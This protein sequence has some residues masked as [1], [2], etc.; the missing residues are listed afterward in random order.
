MDKETILL[1]LEWY[2]AY[3][4][5]AYTSNNKIFIVLDNEDE[6]HVEVSKDEIEYRS[7]LEIYKN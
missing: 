3:G 1:A 2:E 5:N 4:I 7:S 6:T